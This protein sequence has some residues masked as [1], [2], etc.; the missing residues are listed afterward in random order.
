MEVPDYGSYAS[1]S[2]PNTEKGH[3]AMITRMDRDVG[4]LVTLLRDLGLDKKT[5]VFFTSDNGPHEEGGHKHEYFDS[6]GP[7]R[8]Y[9]RDLYEGGIRVP[10]VAWWPGVAPPNS[11]CQTPLAFWDFLPTACELAGAEL[12]DAIDGI[13]F[14]PALTGAAQPQHEFLYWKY[15]KKTAV[16]KGKWKAVRINDSQPAEL[17]DLST[18]VGESKNLA[19]QHPDVVTEL[20]RIMGEAFQPRVGSP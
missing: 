3:A 10:A 4:R 20:Q 6:N 7:L 18:D 8:G 19:D 17:Y 14:V 5:L 15:G 11:Q 12:P 2:W 1:E 9:K 16:R 13:S